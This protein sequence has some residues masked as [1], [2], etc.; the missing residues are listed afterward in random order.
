M[1][2]PNIDEYLEILTDEEVK[3]FIALNVTE[4]F[5]LIEENQ[6]I[7]LFLSNNT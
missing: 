7:A 4:Y 1:Y 6:N 2:I 5:K 3:D